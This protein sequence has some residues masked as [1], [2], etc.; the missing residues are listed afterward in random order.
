MSIPVL[1]LVACRSRFTM[2]QSLSFTFISQ[3]I[4]MSISLLV[5]HMS[6]WYVKAGV[7]TSQGGSMYR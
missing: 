4:L 6:V 7:W 3:S 5:D 2:F 1:K